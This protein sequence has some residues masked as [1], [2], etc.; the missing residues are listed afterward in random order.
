MK[1]GDNIYEHM[2]KNERT[3]FDDFCKVLGLVPTSMQAFVRWYEFKK[4]GLTW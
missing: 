4:S 3:V 1:L 2:T